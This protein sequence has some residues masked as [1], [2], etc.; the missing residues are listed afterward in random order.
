MTPTKP[1]F[2]V[3]V[4]FMSDAFAVHL[5]VPRPVSDAAINR[6]LRRRLGPHAKG[7][8]CEETADYGGIVRNVRG[9][10]IG[11]YLIVPGSDKVVAP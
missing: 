5:R 3:R 8:R 7:Y 11:N 4:I 2:D 10:V 6:A 1:A 9:V